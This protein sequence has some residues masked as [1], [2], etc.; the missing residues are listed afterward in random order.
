MIYSIGGKIVQIFTDDKKMY[1]FDFDKNGFPAFTEK[2][3]ELINFLIDN[4]SNYRYDADS[5]NLNSTYNMIK[6]FGETYNIDELEQIISKIDVQN[7]T[8]QASEGSNGGNKGRRITAEYISNIENLYERLRNEDAE[9]VNEIAEAIPTR[10]TF[11]FAS[12]YCTYMSRYLF[13]ADGYSIYDFILCNIL[14]Y[15]AWVYLGENHKANTKS[16]VAS[17]YGARGKGDYKGYRNLIDR[18]RMKSEAFTGYN[19]KRVDFDHLLWYYFK[20]DRDV[21]S[22]NGD[23][24]YSSRITRA[25]NMVGNNDSRL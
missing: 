22:I 10:Y 16:K 25:L 14:P 17:E 3:V 7:S 11:S 24:I 1:S 12:K 21:K 4:D 20:G 19:I 13:D 8:H 5:Q 15:Y 9:L 23:I 2:N 6:K 18:I